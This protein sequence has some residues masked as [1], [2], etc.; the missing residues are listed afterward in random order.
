MTDPTTI[1]DDI[2]NLSDDP[3]DDYDMLAAAGVISLEQAHELASKKR[4]LSQVASQLD[5]YDSWAE[6][7]CTSVK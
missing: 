5:R 6:R 2:F 7:R 4:M 3:E 1:P